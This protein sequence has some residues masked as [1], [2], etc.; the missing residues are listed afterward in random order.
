MKFFQNKCLKTKAWSCNL[1][2]AAW[3]N[4]VSCLLWGTYFR[5]WNTNFS[6][7]FSWNKQRRAQLCFPYPGFLF[8]C[9]L[10]F[11]II[12]LFLL[13]IFLYYSYLFISFNHLVIFKLWNAF[14]FILSHVFFFLW[15]SVLRQF[16]FVYQPRVSICLL[17]LFFN[18]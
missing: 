10:F 13:F 11:I 4:S 2:Y 15:K 18:E 6:L 12:Y 5:N 3:Y 1:L 17:L 14:L 8:I 7:V 9:L 16:Y